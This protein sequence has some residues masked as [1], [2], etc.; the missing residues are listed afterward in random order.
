MLLNSSSHTPGKLNIAFYNAGIMH[1]S[2]C[3]HNFLPR[4]ALIW[5]TS[6]HFVDG[7]G[8]HGAL[9][10]VQDDDAVSTEEKIWDLT[11]DINLKGMPSA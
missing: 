1:P 2:V 3:A 5:A 4:M 7:C 10:V 11:M 9:L 8:N 6:L